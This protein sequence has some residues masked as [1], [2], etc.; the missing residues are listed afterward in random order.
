MNLSIRCNLCAWQAA[1]SYVEKL[2]V[3]RSC[4]E[5]VLA[6]QLHSA[7]HVVLDQT[8][9]RV[10]TRRNDVLVVRVADQICLCSRQLVL[11]KKA[12]NVTSKIERIKE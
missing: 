7:S 4:E 2:L 12:L 1:Q 9:D 10:T 6:S 5:R 11:C 8:T 3:L